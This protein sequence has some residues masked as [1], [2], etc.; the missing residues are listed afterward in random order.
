[1]KAVNLYNRFKETVVNLHSASLLFLR[2]ILAYGF[3]PAG[4]E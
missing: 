1:M 4:D 2:L 3:L